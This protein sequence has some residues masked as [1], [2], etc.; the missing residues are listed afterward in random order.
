M[1]SALYIKND[2]SRGTMTAKAM[3]NPGELHFNQRPRDGIEWD[4]LTLKVQEA[5][6]ILKPILIE[7]FDGGYLG[8]GITFHPQAPPGKW[9]N[10]EKTQL[11]S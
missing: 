7:S 2:F 4:G 6:E 9:K 10:A 11:Q 5:C 8:N 3:T 1:R